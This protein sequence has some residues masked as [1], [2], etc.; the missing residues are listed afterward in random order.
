MSILTGM[1]ILLD[2]FDAAPGVDQTYTAAY[3]PALLEAAGLHQVYPVTT[4][5]LEGLAQVD[6]ETLIGDKQRALLATGYLRIRPVNLQ[7]FDQEIELVRGLIN[8]AFDDFPYF[9]PMTTEEYRFLVGPT[10][11]LIDPQLVLVAEWEGIPCGFVIAVPN[12]NPLLA[13]MRGRAGPLAQLAFGLRRRSVHEAVGTLMGVRRTLRGRGLMHLLMAELLRALQGGGYQRLLMTWVA[14]TNQLSRGIYAALGGQRLHHLT[15][16]EGP[17][18]LPV[19]VE[20]A[21]SPSS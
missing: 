15:L 3:Y 12:L 5:Q 19:D 13:R 10:R 8:D 18:T 7:A 9:V 1:G 2:G 20:P 14:E 21:S 6:P 17:I 11:D 16:F 4:Y